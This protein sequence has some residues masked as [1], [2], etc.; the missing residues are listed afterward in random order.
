L[1][2]D[3]D[4][5]LVLRKLEAVNQTFEQRLASSLWAS[6]PTTPIIDLSLPVTTY[7]NLK[8]RIASLTTLFDHF[9]KREF[10]RQSGVSTS[11]S[12]NSFI[13]F[14]KVR[15]KDWHQFIETKV[16]AP[17]GKISLLRDYLIHARNKN[18]RTAL[19]FFELNDPI[20][21][22]DDAWRKIVYKFMEVLD[23]L[24]ELLA[25]IGTKPATE[26]QLVERPAGFM[27]ALLWRRYH[28]LLTDATVLSWL[29]FIID[30]DRVA[31]VDLAR[32]FG[33]DVE[34][35]R[36]RLYPLRGGVLLVRPN[37]EVSTILSITP[38]MRELL[39]SG[40]PVDP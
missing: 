17:I 33:L 40:G 25:T 30:K 38:S 10:D 3:F 32:R 37:D 8:A 18:H 24:A 11:G 22:Y 15:F 2:A 34:D 19:E 16:E 7:D 14:L 35:L 6:P 31:D 21:A 28:A 4:I 36:V 39:L 27:A 5:T 9:N 20:A 23:A 29:R 26:A 12:R 13:A 1:L